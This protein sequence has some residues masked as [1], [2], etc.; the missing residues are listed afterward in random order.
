MVPRTIIAYYGAFL[1]LSTVPSRDVLTYLPFNRFQ[2]ESNIPSF[3]LARVCDVAGCI[4]HTKSCTACE[5]TETVLNTL[6]LLSLK[7]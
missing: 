7:R 4:K 1:M 5:G 3:D 2:T 6:K